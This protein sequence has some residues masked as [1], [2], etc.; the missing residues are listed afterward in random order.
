MNQYSL[1]LGA[2]AE[3]ALCWFAWL[4]ASARTR[5]KGPKPVKALSAPGAWLGIAM[6]MLGV[7]CLALPFRPQGYHSPLYTV[8]P[9]MIIAPL[10]V[11]LVWRAR[12]YLG[13]NWHAG[14]V[15]NVDQQLIQTGPYSGIRHPIYASLLGM[16][17]ATGFAYTWWPFFVAGAILNLFGIEIRAR[18]EEKLLERYFQDEYIEY[19][20]RSHAFFRF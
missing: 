19:Q 20:A 8:V 14:A 15:L 5:G 3:L 13:R 12:R 4:L 9:A 2:W 7:A 17:V 11:G 6:N 16:V 18:A 10:S 1:Q